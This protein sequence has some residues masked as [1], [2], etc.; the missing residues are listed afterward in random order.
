MKPSLIFTFFCRDR[1]SICFM[2]WLV[3]LQSRK[4]LVQS[5]ERGRGGVKDTSYWTKWLL[6]GFYLFPPFPCQ[7][8]NEP[9]VDSPRG[10]ESLFSW[11]HA[12]SDL[13]HLMSRLFFFAIV[14][15]FQIV[16]LRVATLF[17]RGIKINNFSQ[18]GLF[19]F[20]GMFSFCSLLLL[21]IGRHRVLWK[22]SRAVFTNQRKLISKFKIVCTNVKVL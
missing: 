2:L 6:V 16:I 22:G 13:L 19:D 8:S 18:F 3:R 10:G 4:T 7:Q 5:I 9:F 11:V 15:E 1:T 20:F 12:L 21:W 14:I 17:N